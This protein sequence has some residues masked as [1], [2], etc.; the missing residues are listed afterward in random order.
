MASVTHTCYSH[1]NVVLHQ[2]RI[3]AS[4]NAKKCWLDAADLGESAA[5]GEAVPQVAEAAAR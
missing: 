1:V 2:T 3:A 4:L 5:P